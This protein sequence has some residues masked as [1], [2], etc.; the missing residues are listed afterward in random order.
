MRY[1]ILDTILNALYVL[2]VSLLT[3]PR[4]VQ[5]KLLFYVWINWSQSIRK[6][7][8]IYPINKWCSRILSLHLTTQS[9]RERERE[10]DCLSIFSS[11][12]LPSDTS[13]HV[14]YLLLC[15][16][17]VLEDI[18][19]CMLSNAKVSSQECSLHSQLFSLKTASLW[20][21]NPVMY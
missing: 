11:L 2:G 9:S 13:K 4:W 16:N 6:L 8:Y 14:S 15:W 17:C 7:V 3:H 12:I 10:R 18:G 20:F 5:L 21:H 1:F 19:A